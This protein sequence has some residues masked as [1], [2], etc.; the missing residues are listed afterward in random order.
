MLAGLIA[1]ILILGASTTESASAQSSALIVPNVSTTTPYLGPDVVLSG[2]ASSPDAI[3]AV[4]AVVQNVA[5][6]QYVQD[7]TGALGPTAVQLESFTALLP[8]PGDMSVSWRVPLQLADG[9]YE[10]T[11]TAT[12]STENSTVL[13][14]IAFTVQ[15][16][17]G[18][19][20]VQL[21]SDDAI[22]SY[23]DLGSE[24]PAQGTIVWTDLAYDANSWLSG[25]GQLGFGGDDVTTIASEDAAG[26]PLIAAYFR[27]DFTIEDLDALGELNLTMLRDDGAVVYVNGQEWA[28]SNMKN[29]GPIRY[30]NL[31]V[32]NSSAIVE[33]TIDPSLLVVGQNNISVEVHQVSASSSDLTFSLNLVAVSPTVA[34]L[35]SD[36]RPGTY[37][38]TAGDMAR[39]ES[40]GD[41]K[42]AAQMTELF[43]TD[44][45]VFIGLGDL[46]Y[47][48]GSI[49]EFTNCYGPSIGQFKDVTWPAPGNHEHYTT[50]NAAGYRDYFGEA[51]G[52]LAGPAGGLWYS[53]DID[54]YWHVIALDSDC[55]G[56][57]V[58][59]GAFNGDGCAVGSEQEIWLRADLEANADKNILA[60]F[61]HPPYTNNHYTD[62]EFTWP[63]WQALTEYG[64]DIT[65]HGHEHHYERYA[66]MNV[67]GE[68]DSEFGARQF[69]IGSGGTY[70][71]YDKRT[72][73]PR[74]E[75]KGTFPDG[76]FDYGVLQL[77][78]RP[79]GYDWKWE[80]ILGLAE[81]DEG[82]SGLTDPF[83][84]GVIDGTV[85]ASGDAEPVADIEVCVVA[86]RDNAETCA[87]TLADGTFAIPAVFTDDYTISY[88]DA[89]GLFTAKTADVT[90]TTEGATA[91]AELDRLRTMRGRLTVD[92]LGIALGGANVCVTSA[93]DEPL[94]TV[95]EADASWEIEGLRDGEYNVEFSAIGYRTECYFDSE[96][97]INPTTV[98]VLPTAD[99]N[100]INAG[101]RRQDGDVN[102][103]G[104]LNILDAF[105]MAQYSVELRTDNG[106]CP[107]TDVDAKI[108][109]GNGD[110][111]LDGR[112]NIADAFAIAECAVGLASEF[113]P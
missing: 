48:S 27:H 78:L 83:P 98:T 6:S 112:H 100:G 110:A 96:G 53:F 60:F 57:E 99:L 15:E 105:T 45:G 35:E 1:S 14:P 67:W 55:R 66:P 65:L 84:T 23:Y 79:D 64:A 42:V 106:P 19:P 97:C 88:V 28:R 9:N 22:W 10:V 63:L 73:D 26:E 70:P 56:V 51:A 30:T 95:V 75:F 94:C 32:S 24:P 113:C 33:G 37:V 7:A 38:L 25:P 61:H 81:T 91:S 47:N 17:V 90:L 74:S 13:E 41:E 82:T 16:A 36:A 71:R 8:P 103:D 102:C 54:E 59:P 107:L 40:D 18:A 87:T 49:Q 68:P 80:P 50:P 109:L 92:G 104:R 86:A 72:P 46:V 29:V 77:W 5:T 85:T 39:C 2:T 12:E 76:T 58:L 89:A 31:A 69:I 44:A 20:D 101:M 21:I 108:Y 34:S 11:I 4:T 111:N 93:P 52:P 43:D 3:I 62:H